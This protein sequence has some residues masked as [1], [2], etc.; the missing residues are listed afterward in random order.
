MHLHLL[1]LRFPNDLVLDLQR[2]GDVFLVLAHDAKVL[3][4]VEN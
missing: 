3:R 2:V 4:V 1:F